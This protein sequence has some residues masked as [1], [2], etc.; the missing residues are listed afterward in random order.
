MKS[1]RIEKQKHLLIG[2]SIAAIVLGLAA[3]GGGLTLGIMQIIK[4]ISTKEYI[5]IVL[6]VLGFVLAFIGGASVVFGIY[7]VWIGSSVKATKGSIAEDNLSKGSVNGKV[8]PKCGCTNTPDV[9]KCQVC[10][11]DLS[12]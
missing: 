12:E 3:F 7:Y 8:C 1:N 10:G 9:D 6:V 4:T 5:R 11:A 2:L